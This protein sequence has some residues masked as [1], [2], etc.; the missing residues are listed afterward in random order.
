[1]CV[2]LTLGPFTG[3]NR[4]DR[5]STSSYSTG[6]LHTHADAINGVNSDADLLLEVTVSV[7]TELLPADA[8]LL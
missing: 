4:S 6:M 1:M 8:E 3:V 5:T 7:T 2:T